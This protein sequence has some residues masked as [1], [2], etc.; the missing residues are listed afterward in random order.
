MTRRALTLASI[1]L[2][3][4]TSAAFAL[5]LNGKWKG[6]LTTPNGDIDTDMVFKVDGEK[7]TGTVSNM[8]GEEQITEGVVK[9]DELS[10]IIMAG[11]GQ[12]KIVYKGKVDGET[13]KF[14]VVLGEFGESDM[15]AKRVS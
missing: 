2:I 5:D 3:A 9:G 7:L 13:V 14:H 8:Y 1:L 11:G 12:F 4:F 10:F 6:T 15:T